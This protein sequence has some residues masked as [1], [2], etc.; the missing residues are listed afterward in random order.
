MYVS[1]IWRLRVVPICSD[2]FRTLTTCPNVTGYSRKIQDQYVCV[3]ISDFVQTWTYSNPSTSYETGISVDCEPTPRETDWVRDDWNG[4]NSGDVR[5]R[6]EEREEKWCWENKQTER[7]KSRKSIRAYF[8]NGGKGIAV[9]RD[10]KVGC[11][12]KK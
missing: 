3:N 11:E 1:D 8:I 12:K 9:E 6:I 5:E 4:K 2:Q 7:G 10:W